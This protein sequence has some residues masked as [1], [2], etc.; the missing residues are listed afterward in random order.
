MS[1]KKTPL[2]KAREKG[3]KLLHIVDPLRCL[4]SLSVLSLKGCFDVHRKL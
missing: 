4:P 3:A 1:K 2:P